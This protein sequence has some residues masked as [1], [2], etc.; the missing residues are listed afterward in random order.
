MGIVAT[1]NELPTTNVNAGDTYRASA[2]IKKVENDENYFATKGDLIIAKNDVGTEGTVIWEVI[3]IEIEIEDS[4]YI[5]SAVENGMTVKVSNG[6][7]GNIGDVI[8]GLTIQAGGGISVADSSTKAED[9]TNT[10]TVA[11]ADT[12]NYASSIIEKGQV[13]NKTTAITFKAIK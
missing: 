11:H 13:Q 7:S 3:E 10:V 4:Q 6:S 9:L 1:Y 5:G 2:N 8:A 12:S